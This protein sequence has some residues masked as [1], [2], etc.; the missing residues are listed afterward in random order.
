M[1]KKNRETET[2]KQKRLLTY[3]Y[4]IAYQKK[5]RKQGSNLYRSRIDDSGQFLHSYQYDCTVNDFVSENTPLLHNAEMK[6]SLVNILTDVKSEFLPDLR[7]NPDIH[8]FQNGLFIISQNQF[9]AYSDIRESAENLIACK[10]HDIAFDTSDIDA[11]PLPVLPDIFNGQKLDK[12]TQEF[13]I[14]LL[15]RQIFNTD[16]ASDKWEILKYK[17]RF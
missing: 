11:I 14:I 3:L 6:Q 5:Y 1:E 7:H 13:L 2:G 15:G 9:I 17:K 8:A 12:P 4:N 10:Y 16:D